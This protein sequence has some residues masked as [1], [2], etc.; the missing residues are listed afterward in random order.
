MFLQRNQALKILLPKAVLWYKVPPGGYV[1]YVSGLVGLLKR[2]VKEN[3]QSGWSQLRL[4]GGPISLS[5]SALA[6]T[7]CRKHA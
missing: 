3:P 2:Q 7:H 5:H 6:H 1:D 4:I